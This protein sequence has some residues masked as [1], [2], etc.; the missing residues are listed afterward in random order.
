[1]K[2]AIATLTLCV[3]A[4]AAGCG[5]DS[6]DSKALLI[7]SLRNDKAHL[8]TEIEQSKAENDQLKQQIETLSGTREQASFDDIHRI[9]SVKITRY[10]NIYDKDK[11]GTRE[12]LIVYIQPTDS[13]GDIVK[14]PGSAEVELWNLNKPSDQALLAKWN[15]DSD[16][17]KKLWFAAMVSTNYRLTFD[18]TDKIE[19]YDTPLTVK[20]TFT[21]QLSGKTFHDQ[22]VIKP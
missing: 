4:V 1:V 19:K 21:D 11:S 7:E 5:N 16:Q 17:M 2:I 12:S 8:T 10:T 15:V 18:V 20:M 14:T 22:R 9:E 13:Q 3:L 6:T